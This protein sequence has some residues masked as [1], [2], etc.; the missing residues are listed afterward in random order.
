MI[1]CPE[2][3]AE[4]GDEIAVCPECGVGEKYYFTLKLMPDAMRRTFF[5][6]ED[7]E[8]IEI[9]KT[10]SKENIRVFLGDYGTIAAVPVKKGF[11]IM[12]KYIIKLDDEDIVLKQTMKSYS[13]TW[14]EISS[15][16][17]ERHG[18]LY[19]FMDKKGNIMATMIMKTG[20]FRIDIETYNTD[21]RLM[22]IMAIIAEGMLKIRMSR[23][24]GI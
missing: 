11:S 24:A 2:C 6:I 4:I 22:C 13:T 18:Y 17:E 19:K 20:A 14:D 1:N 5:M 16:S 10:L 15:I 8:G 21:F 3:G 12:P 7:D 23:P 9:F